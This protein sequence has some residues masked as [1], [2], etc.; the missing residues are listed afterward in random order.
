MQRLTAGKPLRSTGRMSVSQLAIEADV[1]R[2]HLTH[3]H[4][5]LKELF[6]AQVKTAQS[7]P[8]AF[9]RDLSNFEKLKAKHAKLVESYAELEAQVTFYAAV[10]NT[11]ALEKAAGDQK[12]TL[13]D[14]EARRRRAPRSAD[15][16]D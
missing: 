11:M 7:T 3:Q 5:D 15:D 12:A 16:P 10:I 2:W 1:P 13:T 4:V 8:A 6:Q 14:L 9:A